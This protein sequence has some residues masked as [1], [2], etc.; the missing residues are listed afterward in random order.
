[1]ALRWAMCAQPDWKWCRQG[2]MTL[3]FAV[4]TASTKRAAMSDG[5]Q[6]APTTYLTGV[7]CTPPDPA[8]GSR[9][10]ELLQM[11]METPHRLVET[12]VA[13]TPDI[14]EGDRFVV[15]DAEYA[16]R[17]VARWAKAGSLDAYVHLLLEDE[18]ARP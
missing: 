17:A 14:R 1:M 6:G 3:S 7:A 9:R 18:A 4:M 16:V 13:G 12:F 5:K 10:A 8:D 11:G 2:S 15:G